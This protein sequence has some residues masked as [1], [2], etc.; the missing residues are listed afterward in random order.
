MK[1]TQYLIEQ[2]RSVPSLQLYG[3]ETVIK[4]IDGTAMRRSLTVDVEPQW[5]AVQGAR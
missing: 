5:Q 2:Q 3:K 4:E 1:A